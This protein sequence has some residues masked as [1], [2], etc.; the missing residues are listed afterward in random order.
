MQRKLIKVGTSAAVL[1]PKTLLDERHAKIGDV[2]HVDFFSEN[3]STKKS[4]QGID[5]EVIQWTDK[6]IKKHRHLLEKLAKA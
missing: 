5:P 2:I 4:K 3:E 1:V 6:F